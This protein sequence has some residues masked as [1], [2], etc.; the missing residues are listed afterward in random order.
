MGKAILGLLL[1]FAEEERTARK[2]GWRAAQERAIARGVHPTKT[3]VG[4]Q[5]TKAG[6]LV[7]DPDKAGLVLQAFQDRARGSSIQECADLLGISS[8]GARS[9]FKSQTY[10]GHARTGDMVNEAAH[11]PIVPAR[12]GCRTKSA[13]CTKTPPK[14]AASENQHRRFSLSDGQPVLVEF[15]EVVGGRQQPPLGQHG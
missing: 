8:S 7:P 11:E 2:A 4:Y 14:W 13:P 9:M 12:G 6:T 3:P 1:G 10:L 15:Q 5:R